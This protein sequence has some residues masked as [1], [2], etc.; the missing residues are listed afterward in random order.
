MPFD[1]E[2]R[3]ATHEQNRQRAVAKVLVD[4]Y[5]MVV[6]DF[7]SPNLPIGISGAASQSLSGSVSSE[8]EAAHCIPRQLIIGTRRLQDLLQARIPERA[9]AVSALFGEADILPQ[10]FN[11]ADSRAEKCG[12]D[13]A[14]R[15]AAESLVFDA[16]SA[17]S[18]E[19]E[20][21]SMSVRTAFS[22]YRTRATA[23]FRTALLELDEKVK[24][25]ENSRVQ[26]TLRTKE[27][28]KWLQQQAIMRFYMQFVHG[29]DGLILALDPAIVS[30]IIISYE[31]G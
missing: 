25:I 22:V 29:D 13:E 20:K 19:T 10:N 21:L 31:Q 8:T 11:K 30:G 3:A 27:K 12:L 6:K 16:R 24:K 5:C 2:S 23:A 4:L 7:V 18:L 15:F 1:L 14:L 28:D 26:H 17:G 9:L